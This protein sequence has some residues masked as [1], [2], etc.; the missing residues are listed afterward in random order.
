MSSSIAVVAT[1]SIHPGYRQKALAAL[2]TAVLAVLLEP[3][4]EQYVLHENTEV[5]D[6]MVMIE[7]WSSIA[8]L[9]NHSRGAALLALAA[10]L[11][12]CADLEIKKLHPVI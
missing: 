9:D 11:D 3:G 10:A 12:G 6:Q 7:R 1:I 2:H 4:C 5:P 8:D